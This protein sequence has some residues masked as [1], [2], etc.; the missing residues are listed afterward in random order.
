[1]SRAPTSRS[2]RSETESVSERSRDPAANASSARTIT[3]S[4]VDLS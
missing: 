2:L 3:V 1:M 4:S